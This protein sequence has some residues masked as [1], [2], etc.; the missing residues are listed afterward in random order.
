VGGGLLIKMKIMVTGGS[1]FI[2][3]YVVK[4]L[5]ENDHHVKVLDINEPKVK[6]K[7]LEFVKKS[8]LENLSKDMQGCDS[9]FHFAAL[10]G[11]DNSDNKPLETMKINLQ[12]SV[13]VF[14]SAIEAGI[15]KMVYSSSSE[16]YGEPRELPIKEDSVK[17]PVSTYGVSKL[18]AEI[19][20]KAY[21]QESGT[22]IKIVRFFNVYG[23]GQESNWVVPI[24]LNKALKNEPISVFGEGNQTRCF[25][26]VEDIAEGVLTVFEKGKAGEAYNIGNNKP[27]TILELAQIVKEITKSKSEIKKLGFG[28]ETRLKEREIEYRVPDI[29]RMKSLGWQPKT[30]IREGVKRMLELN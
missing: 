4:H 24:F 21:N 19:Y 15:K 20:A 7:N 25:T 18:A 9:V 17:G 27:T 6:H 28:K 13:N 10:L 26:Y 1:G 8:I 30:M 11:V 16:V 3:G 22:D 29:S 12:G 14:K 23:P 2:G 5:L